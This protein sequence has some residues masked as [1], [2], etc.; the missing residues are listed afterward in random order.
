MTI[1]RSLLA[2]IAREGAVLLAV[3]TFLAILGPYGTGAYGWPD[4]WVY[5]TGLIV[6]G[7]VFG[8]LTGHA[9]ARLAPDWPRWSWYGAAAAGLTLPVTAAV[10]AINTAYTGRICWSQLPLT[11]AMVLV[12]ACAVSALGYAL[13][14]LKRAREAARDAQREA[15]SLA[16][17]GAS[18][19]PSPALL[20]KLPARL[21]QA[22]ILSMTAEDHYLRVRTDAGDALILMRLSDAIAACE[23]LDGARTHRSWWVSRAAITGAS[24]SGGRAVL[25]LTDGTQ[26]PVSRSHYAPLREAGWF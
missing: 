19:R 13:D 20:D 26:A 7:A 10:F 24:R 2:R 15:E 6:L 22:A 21:R 4:V 8:H 12:I 23:G 11:A 3:G 1:S 17:A 9:A 25:I 18:P 14:Q 16:A 5:W